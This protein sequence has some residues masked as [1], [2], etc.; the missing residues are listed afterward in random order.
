MS[1]NGF[2]KDIRLSI[3]RKLKQRQNLSENQSFEQ[4]GTGI[5]ENISPK[6][7]LRIPFLGKQ[8]DFRHSK[9]YIS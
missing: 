3:I 7:G 2:N 9:K 6:I 8:G 4:T 1:W 5:S